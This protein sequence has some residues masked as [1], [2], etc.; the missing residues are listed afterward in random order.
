MN[1]DSWVIYMQVNAAAEAI[2]KKK[3]PMLVQNM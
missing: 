2:I 1:I 3:K